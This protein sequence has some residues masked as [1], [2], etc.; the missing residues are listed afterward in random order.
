[1]RITM[2]KKML[3]D[4]SA[5][6]KCADVERRLSDAGLR[7]R[8]HRVVIADERDPESEGMTLAR[9][10]G[11]EVAPFFI[12]EGDE[13]QPPRIFTV[14]FRLLRE[15]LQGAPTETEEVAEIMDRNPDVDFI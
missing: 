7:D 12:V 15:V 5:C 14:Y 2:V 3:A 13:G 11:V 1:V 8:I 10:H 9:Q 4:G 6:R